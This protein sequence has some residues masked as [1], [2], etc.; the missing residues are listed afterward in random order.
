MAKDFSLR[1]EMTVE[2]SQSCLLRNDRGSVSFRTND[3]GAPLSF[4]QNDVGVTR[5]LLLLSADCS[6]R[7]EVRSQS[8]SDFYRSAVTE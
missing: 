1:I 7:I 6:L 3:Y 5:N 8:E 2:I 4:R